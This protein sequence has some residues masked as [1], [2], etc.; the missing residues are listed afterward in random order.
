ML[1]LKNISLSTRIILLITACVVLFATCIDDEKKKLPAEG[2]AIQQAAIQKPDYDLYSGSEKCASCHRDVYEK[3]TA[4]SHFLTTLP[5]TEKTIKGSFKKGKNIFSYN[6]DL[7]IE[8]EKRDSGLFQVVYYKGQEKIAIPFDIIIGSGIKGQSFMY[9]RDNRLFQMPLTYFSMAGQWANSPGF[10]G[11][12]QFD[13]PITSRCLEC[14]STYADVITPFEKEPEEFNHKKMILG[15]GCEKCHG[16]GAKH[17]DFHLQNKQ[18]TQAKF[19]VNPASLSRQ[20][21]LDLCALCHGGRKQRIQPS[22]TFTAGDTLNNYFQPGNTSFGAVDVHGNQHAL[23]AS[24]KC[25]KMSET[26]TCNTCHDPHENERG[27]L[28]VFSQRCTNCHNTPH[29]QIPGKNISVISLQKNCIDCHMPSK[30]SNTIVLMTG[31]GEQKA[32]KFRSHFISIYSDNF[33]DSTKKSSGN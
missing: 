14:H 32:A 6:P 13:R 8:I 5:A 18:D 20:Q 12:V 10:P 7:Y 31:Q 17:I 25:F 15:I 16:P 24:S 4:T 11:K 3:H 9:W 27:K 23:L 30:P 33:L 22:F 19:I 1:K 26:M 21:Q 29:K 28:A 2:P